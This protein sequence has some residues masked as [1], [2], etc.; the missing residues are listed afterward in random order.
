VGVIWAQEHSK[1]S[2]ISW[3]HSTHTQTNTAAIYAYII[4]RRSHAASSKIQK[5]TYRSVH[6][7]RFHGPSFNGEP[8]AANRSLYW[9]LNI[10]PNSSL[11]SSVNCSRCNETWR[12]TRGACHGRGKH[13]RRASLTKSNCESKLQI[14]T[15]NKYNTKTVIFKILYLKN[16]IIF[17]I[18]SCVS[19]CFSQ[20]V[21]SVV[22]L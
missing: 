20:S 17:A 12:L 3:M 19:R 4:E 7:C 15:F 21:S 10:S 22:C 8:T 11:F 1:P 18:L 5:Q 13:V 14:T 2:S 6:G 16:L 9:S